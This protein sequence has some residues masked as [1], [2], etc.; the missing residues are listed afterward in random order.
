MA[1]GG[2][3]GWVSGGSIHNGYIYNAAGEYFMFP[4]PVY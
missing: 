1:V 2:F 3:L 4:L